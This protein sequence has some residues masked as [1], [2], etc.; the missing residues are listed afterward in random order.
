M[1]CLFHSQKP[2]FVFGSNKGQ[3]PC[4]GAQVLR[5]SPHVEIKGCNAAMHK[6]SHKDESHPDYL[7]LI[8]HQD[9]AVD[10]PS[11]QGFSLQIKS[12]EYIND[13]K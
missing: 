5:F 11:L 6:V 8:K 10:D 7:V 3:Y 4:C 2:K 13:I 1:K 12:D 9:V